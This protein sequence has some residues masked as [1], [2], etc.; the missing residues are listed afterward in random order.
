MEYNFSAYM[1]GES[2]IKVS[3]L[4]KTLLPTGEWFTLASADLPAPSSEWQKCAVKMTS[5]GQSDRA[6][7]ELRAEGQGRL[8]V[9]KLSLMPGDNKMGWRADVVDAIKEIRPGILRWGGSTVDPGHYHWKNGIGDRDQRTPWPNENWGRIDPND[10]GMDEFCQF[11]ELIGAQPLICVSFADGA[12]SAHDLAEYCNGGARHR[13]GR[14]ARRQRPSRALSMSS[15]GRS[16]TK[17]IPTTQAIWINSPV[18]S[19]PFARPTPGPR[20]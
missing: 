6:V 8:W 5:I 2:G 7:F 3:V 18:L 17:S 14:K 16:A 15:I 11:C 13:L 1:R 4:L 9:N 19:K 10:V 12:Q 20:S